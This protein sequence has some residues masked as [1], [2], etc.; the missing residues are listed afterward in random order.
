[1]SPFDRAAPARLDSR[2]WATWERLIEYDELL[3]RDCTAEP[4]SEMSLSLMF[5]FFFLLPFSLPV[6]IHFSRSR[7]CVQLLVCFFGNRCI[8]IAMADGVPEA[9]EVLMNDYGLVL[10][11]FN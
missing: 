6:F 8:L 7:F 1:M 2:N 11:C 4:L 9:N 5:F 10:S 3:Y